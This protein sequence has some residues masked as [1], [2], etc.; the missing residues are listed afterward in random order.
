MLR[1]QSAKRAPSEATP[2]ASAQDDQ[3]SIPPNPPTLFSAL[4]SLFL[5]ISKHPAEKGTVAPRAFVE[6]LKSLNELFQGTQHQDAHEFL[7]YLLNK[8][9]EEI[10]TDKNHRDGPLD[11]SHD[12]RMSLYNYLVA[13][14]HEM[15]LSVRLSGHT[16]FG[17]RTDFFKQFLIRAH[18][19]PTSI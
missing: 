3:A 18:T 4:R 1:R 10:Q 8:I 6:K 12:D 19:C 11:G 15:L 5:Y 9:V 14:A 13:A 17:S 7:N 16:L 2:S